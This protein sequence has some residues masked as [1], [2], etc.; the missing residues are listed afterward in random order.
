[1]Y[2]FSYVLWNKTSQAWQARLQWF[3]P[4]RL[5]YFLSNSISTLLQKYLECVKYSRRLAV[6]PCEE[7][8]LWL[9]AI[10]DTS[11]LFHLYKV[12]LLMSAVRARL[13][14]YCIIISRGFTCT[15]SWWPVSHLLSILQNNV[16]Y[17]GASVCV[18]LALRF[19]LCKCHE[20]R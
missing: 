13:H 9:M 6:T 4:N 18:I 20:C 17:T 14:V 7:Q 11:E 2:A 5:C 19:F 8:R 1:M 12:E 16:Y 3:L 15:F 10:L